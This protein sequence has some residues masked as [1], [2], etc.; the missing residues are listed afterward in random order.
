[1]FAVSQLFGLWS[2]RPCTTT[3]TCFTPETVSDQPVCRSGRTH[4]ILC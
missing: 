3:M 1:M 2:A 4:T